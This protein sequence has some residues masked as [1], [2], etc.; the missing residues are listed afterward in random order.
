[1]GLICRLGSAPSWIFAGARQ[2]LCGAAGPS[3]GPFCQKAGP[4]G[5]APRVLADAGPKTCVSFG[6]LS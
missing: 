3:G 1:M 5:S 6:S 2:M 4:H